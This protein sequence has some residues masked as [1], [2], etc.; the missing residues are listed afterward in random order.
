MRKSKKVVWEK[1]QMTIYPFFASNTRNRL[2]KL[3]CVDVA[4]PRIYLEF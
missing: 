3:E 1:L 4:P 2:R